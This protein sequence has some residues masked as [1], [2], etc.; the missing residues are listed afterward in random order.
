VAALAGGLMMVTRW[1]W[2]G[3]GIAL[4]VGLMLTEGAV[5]FF[6]PMLS[7]PTEGSLDLDLVR[8][9][10]KNTGLNRIATVS[11]WAINPNFGSYFGVA[12]LNYA[13]SPNLK[14]TADYIVN[15]LDPF[16]DTLGDITWANPSNEVTRTR[17]ETFL[18][19]LPLYA[20]AG[21]KYVLSDQNFETTLGLHLDRSTHQGGD[22][23]AGQ[24]VEIAMP[25]GALS[26]VSGIRSGPAIAKAEV[27]VATRNASA[28][29]VIRLTLC[30]RS[31]CAVGERDVRTV[32]DNGY[33]SVDFS[34][35]LAVDDS[36]L[37]S[38][39]I[40][41]VGG[42]N[43][44]VLWLYQTSGENQASARWSPP[45]THDG[46]PDIR[47]R[48]SAD[49]PLAYNSRLALVYELPDVRPYYSADNCSVHFSSREAVD[50]D[51]RQA[52]TLTRL[53]AY[54]AG[55][56]A[57]IDG[58][59]APV[60]LADDAFQAVPLP[61]GRSHVE[62]RYRPTWLGRALSVAGLALVAMFGLLV[63]PR[64]VA[65]LRAERWQPGI[66][67]ERLATESAE[68]AEDTGTQS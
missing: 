46:L 2:R 30:S 68:S 26:V 42:S 35:P 48:T 8:F 57:E 50:A 55:W 65:G 9:L 20:Q 53:E 31:Q 43:D 28:D 59:E 23:S 67:A 44:F 7:Y 16:A 64:V 54:D 66:L 21:V 40:E 33:A 14:R 15:K 62:F 45:T 32:Q 49:A 47:L 34:P 25:R 37:L 6:V 60:A 11:G 29:G 52:G 61:P 63:P 10:Q 36:D 19:R 5:W 18:A 3:N 1:N 13:D 27:Q 22:L 39:T 12:Q 56:H 17:W 24:R 4:V 38:M 51:C 58:R 41:K